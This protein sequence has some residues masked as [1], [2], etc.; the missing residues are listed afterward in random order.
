MIVMKEIAK[1]WTKNSLSLVLLCQLVAVVLL[2]GCNKN[3]NPQPVQAPSKLVYANTLLETVAGTVVKS[4]KPTIEGGTTGLVFTLVSFPTINTI[5]VD[6]QGIVSVGDQTPVNEYTVTVKV[7]NAGGEASATLKVKVN[8]KSENTSGP[9]SNLAYVPNSLIVK[10]GIEGISVKPTVDGVRP[11]AFSIKKITPAN[12]EIAIS[13]DGVIAVSKSSAKGVF[14]VEVTA[15][16][17][18]GEVSSTFT[19]TVEEK[20]VTGAPANLVYSPASLI[21]EKGKEVASVL[22]SV[23]GSMPM[24]FTMTSVPANSAIEIGSDGVIKVKNTSEKGDYVLTITAANAQGSVTTTY[25]VSVIDIVNAPTAINYPSGEL[26]TLQGVAKSSDKPTVVGASGEVKFKI[27]TMNTEIAI[28]QATGVITVSDLSSVGSFPVKI[29]VYN[30][31][32]EVS[33]TITVK[34]TSAV[35][36]ITYAS[37][38]LTYEV[39]DKLDVSIKS[40]M[41]QL[42]NPS[43]E[44]VT[45]TVAFNAPDGNIAVDPISGVVTITDVKTAGNY[46]ITVT[47]TNKYG[48]SSTP[49]N[50]QVL[51]YRPSNFSYADAELYFTPPSKI[52]SGISEVP[53]ITAPSQGGS[54]TYTISSRSTNLSSTTKISTDGKVTAITDKAADSVIYTVKVKATNSYGSATATVSFTGTPR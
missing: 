39:Y 27:E 10:E 23:D 3:Q 12:S 15:K 16:N 31:A 54:I 33:T 21:V 37:N 7:S 22:P 6:D 52:G 5:T 11:M 44:A 53:T 36:T 1:I 26:T 32:G 51:D 29:T 18:E 45:Y 38:T 14:V 42:T 9:A 19:V 48:S 34:V 13:K 35:P 4:D 2:A 28:D 24:T 46:V 49:L 8:S 25:K 47:V 40:G 50:L 30:S 41:A 43:G 20:L 17:A